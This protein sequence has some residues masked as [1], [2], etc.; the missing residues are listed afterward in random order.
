V[1]L[2]ATRDASSEVRVS[3]TYKTLVQRNSHLLHLDVAKPTNGLQVEL[4]YGDCG[5]RY[6]NLLDFLGSAKQVHVARTPE[7]VPTPVVGVSFDDWVLRTAGIVFVWLLSEE[8]DQGA[9]ARPSQ[10]N[11]QAAK[12]QSR[13][14]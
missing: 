8:I 14:G 1:H 10:A 11:K 7:S 3:F 6:V 4:W 5:I 13:R 2:E 9:I 12:V